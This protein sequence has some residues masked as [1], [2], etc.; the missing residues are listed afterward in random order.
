MRKVYTTLAVMVAISALVV[1]A[2]LAVPESHVATSHAVYNRTPDEVWALVSDLAAAP[3]WRRGIEDMERVP[4]RAEVWREK[5]RFGEMTYEVERVPGSRR[6]VM[7]IVDH[8]SF[9]GSWTYHVDE[10]PAGATV[11]IT[12]TGEIRNPVF[13]A[14]ARYVLGYH[15][16]M[17]EYLR[18][19]GERFGQAVE[20]EHP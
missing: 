10:H 14:L 9:G 2:G 7:R 3:E 17:D 8:G 15:G 13:R 4:G 20:P 19:L 12:E 11:T 5:G 16:T 1:V 18:S 6:M